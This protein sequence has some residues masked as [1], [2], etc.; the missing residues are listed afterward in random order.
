M[1]MGGSH[2]SGFERGKPWSKSEIVITV[3]FSSRYICSQSVSELLLCRGY[4]RTRSAVERKL[5]SFI[6]SNASLRPHKGQWDVDAVDRWIDEI[7]DHDAVNCLVEFTP[8]DAKAVEKVRQKTK[9]PFSV[10]SLML[11]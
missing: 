8:E 9:K 6:S 2:A 4:Q 7:L 10:C 1:V 5:R 3:Y 11:C